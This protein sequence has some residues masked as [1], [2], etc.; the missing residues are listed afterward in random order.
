[1]QCKSRLTAHVYSHSS[2]SDVQNRNIQSNNNCAV[3]ML[4]V[5]H[6]SPTLLCCNHIPTASLMFPLFGK[7]T[8]TSTSFPLLVFTWSAEIRRNFR[9]ALQANFSGVSNIWVGH[10]NLVK[11]YTGGLEPGQILWE[12]VGVGITGAMCCDCVPQTH[13]LHSIDTYLAPWPSKPLPERPGGLALG[14]VKG[15]KAPS[16]RVSLPFYRF[17]AERT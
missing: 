6:V 2:A 7:K 10:I 13:G 4:G 17:E 5:S 9:K 3:P 11:H 16:Y 8:S 14:G 12:M 1:M 15:E